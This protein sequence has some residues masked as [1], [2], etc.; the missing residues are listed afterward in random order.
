MNDTWGRTGRES[1][2]A[3]QCSWFLSGPQSA[4]E[5]LQVTMW[6]SSSGF[7]MVQAQLD[8]SGCIKPSTAAFSEV[9][10]PTSKGQG[11]SLGKTTSILRA[12]GTKPELWNR[13]LSPAVNPGRIP[14]SG[15]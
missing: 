12:P 14:A 7:R 4:G 11:K 6:A 3:H 10:D 13:T 15:P 9:L 2:A 8:H 5:R 1:R